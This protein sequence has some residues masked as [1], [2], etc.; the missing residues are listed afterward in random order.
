MSEIAFKFLLQHEGLP[1]YPSRCFIVADPKVRDSRE[2][3]VELDPPENAVWF[4]RIDDI[5]DW[6]LHGDKATR[7]IIFDRSD[8]KTAFRN[9]ERDEVFRAYLRK[10]FE[11]LPLELQGRR[12]Y[13]LMPSIAESKTRTRYKE[14]VEAAI[15]GITVLPEPEMVGEYFRLLKGTLELEPGRNNVI[16]V[17]DVGASTANMTLIVSRRDGTIVDVDETGAERDLRL[18]ALRGDSLDNAG[19][20]VDRRLAD[21][22]GLPD[23]PDALLAI[24]KAKVRTSLSGV[25]VEFQVAD[26]AQPLKLTRQTLATVSMELWSALRPLFERLC[27]RLFDNQTSSKEAKRL[28]APWMRERGV[29]TARN[30]HKLID[31]ILLAGGTSLLPGFEEAM[32]ETLFPDDDHPKVLRVGSSF[33]IAAAA[34]G[35]AHVLQNYTPPRIRDN[36]TSDNELFS[37]ALESTLPDSL[38]LG[39]K[40][41]G[42][43]EQQIT[44][45]DANDPFVDDGG[46]RSIDGLPALYAGSRPKSRLIPGPGAG[47]P[48]RRGRPF[49]TMDVRQSPGKMILKWDPVEQKANI[50]SE[51]IDGI[52]HLWIDA[53]DFRRRAEPPLNPFD[54]KLEPGELAVDGA[55]DIIFDLGMSK[56]VAVTAERGSVS[57]EELERIMLEGL[58]NVAEAPLS[59]IVIAAEDASLDL[60]QHTQPGVNNLTAATFSEV[61]KRVNVDGASN[62]EGLAALSDTQDAV[63]AAP[64]RTV[65]SGTLHLDWGQRV[66]ETVFSN[67]LLEWRDFVKQREPHFQFEDVVVTLLA[68]S[69]RPVVLLAGPPGCGKS[70]LVRM[71]AQMLGKTPGTSFHEV[72]VQAHWENDDAL[73][74]ERGLLRK[75][76]KADDG[77]HIVLFDEFNLTRPEYYLSRFFHA[78]DGGKGSLGPDI[79][80]APCRVLGTMNVDDFSRPPSPK[81]I[82]RSFLLELSQVSWNAQSS[83]MVDI[84]GLDPLPGLPI[85]N[86]GAAGTDERIER[87]L[88]ALSVAVHEHGLRHDLLPS[89]RVLADI[90]A[91]LNLHHQLDLQAKG[92]LDRSD[93]VDRLIESRILVKIAGAIDQVKQALDA[94]EQAVEGA[95]ELARTRRRLKL[96]RNQARLGFVSPWQ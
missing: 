85:V 60:Q 1:Y 66:S 19:R 27:D 24:E 91:I 70:S 42:D 49:R 52:G 65:A 31:T 14:A 92:L 51:Q 5:K 23:T 2:F 78:L 48:A 38:L 59:R 26:A 67:A 81:V 76:L 44:I 36:P 40:Q 32:M 87:L 16:L 10:V 46:S 43:L 55:E 68:L 4:H 8:T 75:I 53:Q 13:A 71:V 37:A 22:L 64:N 61:T 9:L 54:G 39:I 74:G 80:I 21:I 3:S 96:A 82:D 95:E 18:R 12:K 69:V 11:R 41:Q 28:S 90:K 7:Q 15:P 89:R 86:L 33:A 58:E 63:A 73:F 62:V 94:L 30:A 57:S 77:E 88:D 83:R 45:L 6:M 84:D 17:V 50:I 72:A 25:P 34:G 29:N 93:L 20:W 56:I 47:Q 79:L 35:L